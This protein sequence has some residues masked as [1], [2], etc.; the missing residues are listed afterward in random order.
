MEFQFPTNL[1]NVSLI[2]FFNSSIKNIKEFEFYDSVEVQFENA[3]TLSN[4]QNKKF[5]QKKI[6]LNIVQNSI[7]FLK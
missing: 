3:Q 1:K 7:N 4:N 5:F 6:N 2:I